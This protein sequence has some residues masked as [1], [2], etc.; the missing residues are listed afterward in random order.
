MHGRTCEKK[1]KKRKKLRIQSA[2]KSQLERLKPTIGD[3]RE[4]RFTHVKPRRSVY[5]EKLFSR[6]L[7]V[8]WNVFVS[9]IRHS[10]RLETAPSAEAKAK[11]G[12]GACPRQEPPCRVNKSPGIITWSVSAGLDLTAVDCLV[13]SVLRTKTNKLTWFNAAVNNPAY[14][15]PLTSLQARGRGLCDTSTSHQGGGYPYHPLI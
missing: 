5:P 14:I 15:F 11:A 6:E 10:S 4:E 2:N 8:L 12:G 9:F 7:Y 3:E 13:G 1:E